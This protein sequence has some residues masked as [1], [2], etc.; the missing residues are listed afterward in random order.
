MLLTTAFGKLVIKQVLTSRAFIEKRP[1]NLDAEFVYLE[2]LKQQITGMDKVPSP[3]LSP[4]SCPSAC[5]L[6]RLGLDRIKADDPFTVIFTSGSTGEPKGV[7]LSQHNIASN[8][9]AVIELLRLTSTDRLLGVLPF[10]HAFGFTD[11][12]WLP[13]SSE[14]SAVYHFNPLD[15]RTVGSLV[16]KHKCTILIA[17]PTFLRSYLKRCTVE[18]MKTM[19]LVIVGAEKLPPDLRLAF[20]R[21][22][23]LNRRKATARRKC[24][25]SLPLMFLSL[26]CPTRRSTK[27]AQNMAP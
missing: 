18:E 27:S 25:R 10:F 19:N 7:V 4:N 15:A 16:E 3:S 2:D 6:R 12:M 23:D 17:T 24:P 14:P 11:T 8:V 26:E 5:C 9:D 22:S 21:N 20:R 1:M 13:L